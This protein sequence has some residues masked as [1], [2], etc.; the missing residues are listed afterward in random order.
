[1]DKVVDFSICFQPDPDWLTGVLLDI[2]KK[3]QEWV[4]KDNYNILPK[5]INEKCTIHYCLSEDDNTYIS[6]AL[7]WKCEYFINWMKVSRYEDPTYN[8]LLMYQNLKKL[9]GI[10]F[11]IGPTKGKDIKR[12]LKLARSLDIKCILIK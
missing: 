11:F 8:E 9:N 5:T 7:E 3:F 2:V 4:I 10:A 1:M 6:N 12:Q